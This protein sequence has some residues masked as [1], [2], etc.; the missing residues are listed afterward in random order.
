MALLAADFVVR[1]KAANPALRYLCDPV[2]GDHGPGL[3]VPAEL[4]EVMRDRLLPLAF[5]P[6]F[7]GAAAS[8]SI[9]AAAMALYMAGLTTG[10]ALMALGHDRAM[11]VITGA[12]TAL[13][14]AALIPAAR[15]WGAEGAA[16]MQ[17]VG[18]A[19]WLAACLVVALAAVRPQPIQRQA[20]T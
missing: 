2:M 8:V 16:A 13:F 9:M 17:L 14:F 5:G 20:A 18:N 4:A 15:V 11:T 12:T 3:Y 10:P 6:A 7:A 1:A 19:L